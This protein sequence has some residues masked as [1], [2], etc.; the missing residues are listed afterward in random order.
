MKKSDLPD[1]FPHR[2]YFLKG[3]LRAFIVP[4]FISRVDVYPT[5]KKSTTHG[6]QVRY[7][8]KNKFFND[9]HYGSGRL[10]SPTKSLQAAIE[11]LCG[12]YQG[13]N[14]RIRDT[15]N[16]NKGNQ[17]LDVGL[18]MEWRSRAGRNV[19]ELSVIASSP[20]RKLASPRVYVGT[21]AT[22]TQARINEA[23]EIARGIRSELVKKHRE[24]LQQQGY[25]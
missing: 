3:Y 14:V 1:G 10:G 25:N 22:V 20:D 17:E 13:P 5:D 2:Q 8:G 9:R 4:R 12:V 19:R 7:R 21:E 23:I 11:H 16:A 15:N 24:K 18:R 6:W